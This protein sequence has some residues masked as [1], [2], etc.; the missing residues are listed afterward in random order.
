M[1][2]DVRQAADR[3]PGHVVLRHVGEPPDG[4]PPGVS[5]GDVREPAHGDA[6]HPAGDR[7]EAA[8]DDPGGGSFRDDGQPCEG[9]PREVSA[10]DD[11]RAA[12]L[13]AAELAAGRRGEAEGDPADDRLVGV[14]RGPEC[15]VEAVDLLDALVTDV[16]A[17]TA[18]AR[19]VA[20]TDSVPVRRE[21]E[22]VVVAVVPV[23]RQ[24]DL[25][26]A[27]RSRQKQESGERQAEHVRHREPFPF[28]RVFEARRR[29]LFS[30]RNRR[31]EVASG[32]SSMEAVAGRVAFRPPAGGAGFPPLSDQ[33]MPSSSSTRRTAAVTYPGQRVSKSPSATIRPWS[34]GS[35]MS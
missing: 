32:P 34:S 3:D 22:A 33:S 2:G 30:I 13:D 16:Q 11:R 4:D 27:G 29:R 35:P 8:D 26:G 19:G 12:D 10:G 24:V 15:D 28:H 1:L 5:L 9:D 7:G 31:S 17:D 25:D 20:E 18:E 21:V 14:A 23:V 6:G